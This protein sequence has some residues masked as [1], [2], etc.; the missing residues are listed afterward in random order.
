MSEPEE[1]YELQPLPEVAKPFWQ[2]NPVLLLSSFA[3]FL[4][5]CGVQVARHPISHNGN[6]SARINRLVSGA[7]HYPKIA[8]AR[9]ENGRVSVHCTVE[10]NG[11]PVGCNIMQSTDPV[12]NADAL[13]FIQHAKFF[14][15]MVNGNAVEQAH[16]RLNL[17]FTWRR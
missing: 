2:R 11:D 15:A 14:P 12:F 6:R 17:N 5:V 7:P 9:H 13:Y 4:G 8:L 3:I 1:N 10:A 16:Y